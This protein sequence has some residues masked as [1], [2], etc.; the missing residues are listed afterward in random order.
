MFSIKKTTAAVFAIT[1]LAC[2]PVDTKIIDYEGMIPV[3]ESTTPIILSDIP[4]SVAPRLVFGATGQPIPSFV[5]GELKIRLLIDT[6]G[7]VKNVSR[8][9]GNKQLWQDWQIAAQHFVFSIKPDTISGPWEFDMVIKTETKNIDESG[10]RSK[11]LRPIFRHS[12]TPVAYRS[13]TQ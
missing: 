5:V 3:E 6:D 13:A 10:S 2:T 4:T 12:F 1:L 8:L 11:T 7:K 9:G